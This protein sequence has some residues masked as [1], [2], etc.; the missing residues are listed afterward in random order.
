MKQ[1][2]KFVV[3]ILF[4]LALFGVFAISALVLVTIG[5]D[6]YQH[7]VRDMS[8]NYDSRTATAYITEKVRRAD[9]RLE[10][11][12]RAVTIGDFVDTPALI[13]TDEINGERFATYLYYHEG[14]LRE[15]YIR[16]NSYFGDEMLD[17]GQKILELD[18]LEYSQP[19]ERLIHV[20]MML[21]DQTSKTLYLSLKCN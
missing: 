21:P 12:S 13:L 1:E 20:N 10:D 5:A 19:D 2:R 14:W 9:A 11:G 4:V 17:A 15:L 7:T 16:E 6:V 8:K 18:S 3:D